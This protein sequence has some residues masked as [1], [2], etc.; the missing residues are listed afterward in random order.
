MNNVSDGSSTHCSITMEPSTVARKNRPTNVYIWDMDETLI[1]LKSLLN[2]AYMQAFGGSKDSSKGLEI[3]KRWEKQ[4]LQVCDDHFFYEQIE[5][6]NEPFLLSLN[7]FDDGKDLSDYNFNDD[8]LT[9]PCD[10]SNKRKLAYRHRA[11]ANKYSKGLHNVLDHNMIKQWDDLYKLTDI[12]TDGWL[13]SARA[14]LEQTSGRNKTDASQPSSSENTYDNMDMKCKDINV[15]V[16]SGS[17]IPSLVKCMLF[18]L[19]DHIVYENVYSSWEVGKLQCFAWIRER[20]S[21][22]SVR[23]CVI[24]DGMEECDAAERMRWPFVKMDFRPKAPHRF[25]GLTVRIIEHYM[26]V[27]YGPFNYPDDEKEQ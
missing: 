22:P 24:G 18:H 11:I 8:G 14:L 19:D 25:P 26:E 6:Y 3:G 13:S 1:L 10:D 17:L 2:G 15:L 21:G 7:E 12:Y 27:I 5:D 4:I 9:F 23:F 20:F 16:T